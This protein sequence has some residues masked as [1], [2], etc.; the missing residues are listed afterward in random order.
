[1]NK[2]RGQNSGRAIYNP[3]RWCC[4][5]DALSTSGNLEN[6]RGHRTGKGQFF[7]PIPKKGNVKECLDYSTAVLIP[8]AG[9][10][11]P[12]ILQ[13]RLQQ[14][15]NWEL[16]DVQAGFRKGRE[17]RDRISNIHWIIEK[18]TEF[19]KKTST[20]VSVT[21]LKPLTVWITTNC[22]KFLKR[23]EYQTTLPASCETC[24]QVKKQLRSKLEPDMEKQSGSKLGKEYDKAVYG[25]PAYSTSM[26]S[27][28][29]EVPA[30]WMN[31]KLESK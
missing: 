16:S 5:S 10:F 12:K 14:Y 22:G 28:P 24:M 27:T 19:Q 6:S 21:T 30:G 8:H 13:V 23:W 2:L 3:E 31:H 29:C 25:H 4:E 20:S 18:A 17:T 1:M 26:Q 11:I 7:I 15:M 9:K